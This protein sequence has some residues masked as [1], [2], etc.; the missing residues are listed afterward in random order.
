MSSTRSSVTP[1][2]DTFW[3]NGGL[4]EITARAADT[5]RALGVLEGRFFELG[6]EGWCP[7]RPAR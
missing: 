4:M 5:G 7:V 1:R 3:W 6:A 2:E